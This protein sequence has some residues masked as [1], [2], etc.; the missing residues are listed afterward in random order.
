MVEFESG[1]NRASLLTIWN[2]PNITTRLSRCLHNSFTLKNVDG[3]PKLT[4]YVLRDK[5]Q[6]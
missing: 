5:L 1:I 4:R 2:N 3:K 6:S